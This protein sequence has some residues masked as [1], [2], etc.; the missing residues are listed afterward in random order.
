QGHRWVAEARIG[1]FEYI[2]NA[3]AIHVSNLKR[4]GLIAHDC[5]L[6]EIS[7]AVAP[8]KFEF[9]WAE[10]RGSGRDVHIPVVVKISDHKRKCGEET[11]SS[12]NRASACRECTVACTEMR[13]P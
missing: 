3:I 7:F 5:L 1:A 6:G 2:G 8:Q 13:G 9:V 12:Q 4:K 11:I 10:R